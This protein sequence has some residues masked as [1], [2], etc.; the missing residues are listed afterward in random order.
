VKTLTDADVDRLLPMKDAIHV[1]EQAFRVKSEGHLV[2]P[3]RHY[4]RFSHGS[5]VFT[6]GG[7][8]ARE[9]VVGFRV[10]NTFPGSVEDGGVH[11]D[12]IQATMVFDSAHGTLQ[13]TILGTRLGVLRTSAIGGTALKY[14]AN[15]TAERIG[16]IGSGLQA[17]AQL[18]AAMAVLPLKSLCVFSPTRAHREKFAGWASEKFGLA[19][20]PSDTARA[21]AE[22][23]DVVICSTVSTRPVIEAEWIR[24]GTH[25]TT[26]GQ[27]TKNGHEI[28]VAVAAQADLVAA[29]SPA[30]MSSYDEPSLFQGTTVMDRVIDL[31]EIVAG[32]KKGRTTPAQRTVFLSEGLAGTEVLLAAELLRRA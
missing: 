15:P 21:V 10:Y 32:R 18:E 11:P 1:M 20:E 22:N 28:D 25:L 4:V 23:S 16:F 30:Q 19:A 5:L 14:L 26:M 2:S 31:A 24:P 3:P 12:R 17:G 8:D 13:G 6:V 7:T 29:D 9:G 27:R